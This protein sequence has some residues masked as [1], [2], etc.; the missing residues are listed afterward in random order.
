MTIMMP[1]F[2]APLK[3]AATGLQ[4]FVKEENLTAYWAGPPSDYKYT[5]IAT[6]PSEVTISYFPKNADIGKVDAS[7]LVV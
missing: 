6:T 1:G 4:K 3:K 7:I 5:L 2:I